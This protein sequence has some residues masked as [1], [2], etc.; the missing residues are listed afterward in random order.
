MTPLPSPV[1]GVS[2]MGF[3]RPVATLLPVPT[4]GAPPLFPTVRLLARI[5]GSVRRALLHAD[6]AASCWVDGR[7]GRAEPGTRDR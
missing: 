5:S 3:N 6:V 2:P 7:D 4:P 1:G